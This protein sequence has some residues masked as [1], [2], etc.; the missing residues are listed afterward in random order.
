MAVK[1]Y[2]QSARSSS[3]NSFCATS[4]CSGSSTAMLKMVVDEMVNGQ[5]KVERRI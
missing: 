3:V 1:Q 4:F 2:L 5:D